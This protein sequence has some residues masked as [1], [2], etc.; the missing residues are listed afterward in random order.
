MS[1]NMTKDKAFQQYEEAL[2]R[3]SK[4][5]QEATEKARATLYSQ[6]AAIR[7][8]LHEEL[9]GLRVISQKTKR[10]K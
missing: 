8:A 5:A 1:D 6:L 7:A 3:I 2:A 9:R 4:D 10:S